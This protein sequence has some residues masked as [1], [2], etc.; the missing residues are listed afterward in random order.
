[1][2]KLSTLILAAFIGAAGAETAPTDP[3]T[4]WQAWSAEAELKVDGQRKSDGSRVQFSDRG[5]GTLSFHAPFGNFEGF[6]DGRL[7][8]QGKLQ[9][10]H[11][12]RSVEVDGLELAADPADPLRLVLNDRN[13][14]RLFT[15]SHIH[16]YTDLQRQQLVMERMDV[17]MSPELAERLGAERWAERFVGEL[18]LNASLHIPA[19]ALTENRGTACADRPN[20]STDGHLLDVSLI[21]MGF[22]D[23][24]GEV[25][26]NGIDMEIITPSA[27]LRNSPDLDMAD[28]PWFSKFSGSFPPYNNDQH[29]YLVWN[30]YRI[31]DG[32][33]E[34]IG[35]SGVKHAWLTINVNCTINCGSGGIPNASGHILWPGCEDVYGVG[36]NDADGD[37]GPRDEINPRTG[38]FVSRGS[39]FDSNS[40]GSQDNS[41]SANGENRMKVARSDLQTPD[42]EYFFES[43]Y[44]I[45]DDIDIFNSMGYHRTTPS[46]SGTNWS[47]GLGPFAPGG[48]VDEWVAPGGSPA[49]GAMN[50]LFENRQVGHFKVL[51]RAEQ[52]PSDRWRYSYVVMNYD[53]DHGIASFTVEA[54]ATV[55]TPYFHDPDQDGAND[56]PMSTGSEIRFDAPAGNPLSW[57]TAYSFGFDSDQAPVARST[58]VEFGPTGPTDVTLDLLGPALG[59]SI[60]SNGFETEL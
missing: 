3:T 15:A 45:R 36:N 33:L 43:W 32:R 16:V 41:S 8:L 20:W 25:V 53:V 13:G 46:G 21:A 4:E 58:R 27:R 35:V 39:F 28:V 18:A 54:D 44:V 60:F 26:E 22:V 34:H 29:P 57:G 40:D 2:R 55:D 38:I 5:L 48:A 9:F 17:R 51:A 12:G 14:E 47:Y 37:L 7:L 30:L 1:M 24:R 49:S 31:A 6:I 42:A 10:S 50:V 11:A 19:G 52:L 59:E 23:D 56:W